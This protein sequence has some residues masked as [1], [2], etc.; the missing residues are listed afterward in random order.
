[1][2]RIK[3]LE[4]I[5]TEK[6]LIIAGLK[7]TSDAGQSTHGRSE[8]GSTGRKKYIIQVRD[9]FKGAA[10]GVYQQMLEWARKET[11]E[12]VFTGV[13][14]RNWTNRSE[15]MDSDG[16]GG[17]VRCEEKPLIPKNPL[18]LYH[19]VDVTLRLLMGDPMRFFD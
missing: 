14:Q 4:C 12:L 3:E 19:L 18:N 11:S 10:W 17:L 15:I 5:E 9:A 7:V 13:V 1:M 2:V 8:P 16:V 6:N